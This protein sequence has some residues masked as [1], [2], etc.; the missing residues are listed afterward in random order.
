MT[1]PISLPRGAVVT[2]VQGFA[3]TEEDKIRLRN[4]NVGGVILFRRNFVSVS[5][6]KQLVNEIKA[7]RTPSLVVAV[8]HEGGRVQRFIDG[9]TR[10]PAMAEIGQLIEQYD[11]N[12]AKDIAQKTGFVLAAELRACGI[13]LSFTP[14]LDLD[15]GNCAVIGNRSFHR[16]P[17]IVS[18]LAISLH[19]GLHQGGMSSC[20]KHFPG[21]GY[22]SGDSHLELPQDNRTRKELEEDLIPFRKMID[23]GM[24]AVMPAHVVY[25]KIDK[26]PAGFSKYWLE[27]T[28]RQELGFQ[29]IIFSDDLTMEGASIAGNIIDRANESFRAGC[30]VVLVCN[31][32]ELTDELISNLPNTHNEELSKRWEMVAGKYHQDHFTKMLQ[33]DGFRRLAQQIN[34]LGTKTINNINAPKVG[35]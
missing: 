35:E 16:D 20:G 7:L 33:T 6:L 32:P 4:P 29:G 13:D 3:L 23:V 21:H 1:Q 28:L 15:Y 24:A 2:D 14:V 8:D 17:Q 11:L 30:D 22:V 31:Q 12:Y 10:I 25:Q 19:T 27:N 9:F 5:Q 18:E 26:Y 34:E